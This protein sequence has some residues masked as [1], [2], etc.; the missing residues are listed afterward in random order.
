MEAHTRTPRELF[1]G[2]V[3]YVVPAFQRPYVWTQ[4]NQWE[5]LWRDVTNVAEGLIEPAEARQ[6]PRHFL[7]AVVAAATSTA[8]GDVV[9]RELI[10]GQQRMTTIQLLLDALHDVIGQRGHVDEAEA[11]GELV[12]NR[13]DRFAKDERRFKLWPSETDRGAFV[14]AMEGPTEGLRSTAPTEGQRLAQAHLWFRT[15]AERWISGQTPDGEPTIVGD[16]EQRVSA[17]CATV[18]DRLTLV[19]IDLDNEDDAQLIFETLNDRG[20]PLLGADLIKNWLFHVGS[21]CGADVTQWAEEWAELDSSW[22]RQEVRQGRLNRPRVDVFFQY[23]ITANSSEEL[24][25]NEV[26]RHF[27]RLAAQRTD[28]LEGAE[29]L[30]HEI[31]SDAAFYRKL[32]DLPTTTPEGQFR[33]RVLRDFDMSVFTPLLLR[34]TPDRF[35]IPV[36]QRRVALETV[37][38]WVVRRALLFL[39]TGSTNRVLVSLLKQLK[40]TDPGDVGTVTRQFFS[41]SPSRSQIWPDDEWLRRDLPDRRLYG[42]LRTSKLCVVLQVIDDH[43]RKEDP[44]YDQIVIGD[45]P[46]IEHIM[47]Q[48]WQTNWTPTPRNLS[49][50]VGQ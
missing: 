9:R 12:R 37:E 34:V 31:L 28:T 2:N 8:S 44:R 50:W 49:T 25:A 26:F 11:L 22:W 46:Q 17:L 5:P 10:D 7:G 33:E 24:R 32:D 6:D 20:T 16:E 14:G 40:D 42:G 23:W 21:R 30:L 39:S 47:P 4:E 27:V 48:T 38:S 43:L 1:E 35:G 36:E 13:S 15:A 45:T 19:A 29:E 18:Q 3:Q 41:Q